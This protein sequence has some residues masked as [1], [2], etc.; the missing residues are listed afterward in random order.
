MRVHSVG[1]ASYPD[2]RGRS[3]K[4]RVP[5]RSSV[6]RAISRLSFELKTAHFSADFSPRTGWFF[7]AELGF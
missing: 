4:F 3:S 5:Q 2:E 1:R 7:P 6:T